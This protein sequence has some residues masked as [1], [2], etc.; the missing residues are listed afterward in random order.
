MTFATRDILFLTNSELG[1]CNV[2]LAVAEEFLRRGDFRVHIA[3]FRPLAP[4]VHELNTRNDGRRPAEFHEIWGP[5]MTDLAVRSNVGLLYHRPGVSGAVEGFT[6][7]STAMSNWRPSEYAKAYR[8]CLDILDKLRPM[9]VVVDPILHVGLDA[10]Q[11]T[12]TRIVVL[13]PVPLKDVVVLNQPKVGALWK[14]PVYAPH[15]WDDATSE[16]LISFEEQG[17]DTPFHYRGH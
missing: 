2:A 1:Q 3:S 5:C 6:K 13:W 17:Q 14:Y 7:V 12:K 8:S 11:S 9:A 16:L 15:V 10:C 4:L